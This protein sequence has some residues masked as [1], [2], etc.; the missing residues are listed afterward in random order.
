MKWINLKLTVGLLAIILLIILITRLVKAPT[1]MLSSVYATAIVVTG[2]LVGSLIVAGVVKLIFTQASFFVVFSS[3][4]SIASIILMFKFYSPTLTIIVPKGYVGRITMVLS[5]V[6]KDILTVD[7]NGIGYIT[8]L[9]F[10]KTYTKPV[11]LETDSTDI[12]NQCV[13]FSPSTFWAK[14]VPGTHRDSNYQIGLEIDFLSFEVVPK[15]KQ[16]QKQ[17]Y[18]PD[19]NGLIDKEKVLYR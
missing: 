3:V 4:V 1:F 10:D 15:D 13:G 8:K 18:S 6:N 9:T 19:L 12:S 17:Y 7:S 2:L 5:N 16:G 11:V 14:T